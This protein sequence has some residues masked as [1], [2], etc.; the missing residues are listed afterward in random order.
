MSLACLVEVVLIADFFFFPF[1]PPCGIWSSWAK[2]QIRAAVGTYTTAV[3]M[4]DP[5][6]HYAWLGIKPVSWFCREAIDPVVPQ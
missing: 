4:S 1:W 6:T 3:A 5:L 2:D